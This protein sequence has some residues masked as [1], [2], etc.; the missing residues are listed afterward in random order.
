M[1]NRK[2]FYSVFK[3]QSDLSPIFASVFARLQPLVDQVK[4]YEQQKLQNTVSPKASEDADDSLKRLN[5]SKI[6]GIINSGDADALQRV[7]PLKCSIKSIILEVLAEYKEQGKIGAYLFDE[8]KKRSKT[9]LPSREDQSDGIYL[10]ESDIDGAELYNVSVLE[11]QLVRLQNYCLQYI[12]YI[13]PKGEST[14]VI[15][16][17]RQEI[18]D[19]LYNAVESSMKEMFSCLCA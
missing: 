7:F 3:R 5:V 1:L 6:E 16:D 2:H 9:G 15:R 18:A 17:I 11:D 19:R 14:M 10:Y 12:A 13:E 4:E 8:N